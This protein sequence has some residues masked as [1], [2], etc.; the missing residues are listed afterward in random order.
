M[1][2]KDGIAGTMRFWYDADTDLYAIESTVPRSEILSNFEET[3][4][5]DIP[6]FIIDIAGAGRC[7]SAAMYVFIT[8]L[9][10]HKPSITDADCREGLNTL[11]NS[12]FKTHC[13]MGDNVKPFRRKKR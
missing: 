13:D 4:D 3:S 10:D 11:I 6:D 2:N 1:K 5:R 9:R 12:A 8:V 7:V